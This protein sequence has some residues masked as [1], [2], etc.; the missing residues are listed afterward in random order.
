MSEFLIRSQHVVADGK[1][2]PG[3]IRISGEKITAVLREGDALPHGIPIEDVGDAWVFPGLV[4]THVHINE[5]GRTEWEGFATA[6]RAAAA[7]GIT[8]LVDMPLNSDPVTTNLDALR[9]KIDAT[10]NQLAVDVGFH[11][12]LVPGNRDD[13][14]ALIDAGVCGAKAFMVYSGIPEFPAAKRADLEAGMR[15]LAA[16][17]LPLLA[18]AELDGPVAL[19]EGSPQSYARYLASRPSSWEVD[20]IAMLLELVASTGCHVHIVHLATA[21][22]LPM[23]A[24]A[25][26][27]GLPVSVETCPHYLHLCAE[28]IPDGATAFKCAPPIR[29]ST[30]R[31]ALWNAL[32][33]GQIDMVASDHSP[34]PPAMKDPEGGDFFKAWGGIASLQFGLPLMIT[35]CRSRGIP[36]ARIADW[37]SAFPATLGGLAATKGAIRPGADADLVVIDP[38]RTFDINGDIIRHRHKVT[39][40]RG[41]TLYGVVQK[42][43]LRGHEVYREQASLDARYGRCLFRDTGVIS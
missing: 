19:P 10:K 33:E 13:L 20:A 40:Y 43:Y 34:C 28:D 32:R 36:L 25:R 21:D 5:P 16:H 17:G 1:D 37:M 35:E 6:T 41:E 3:A 22:A 4:D 14:E 15:L 31:E 7:G 23:L 9:A 2:F 8:S 11:A 18:H 26:A 39:P 27:K 29:E 24:A 30:H 38:E 12:G 42:T